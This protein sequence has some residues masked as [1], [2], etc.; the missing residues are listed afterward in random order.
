MS[1]VKLK[2]CPFCGNEA[3]VRGF[4]KGRLLKSA[5]YTVVTEKADAYFVRCNVCGCQTIVEFDA[6]ICIKN[7]NRRVES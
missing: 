4:C 3:T 1:E 6:D 5:R 7:W 2:P